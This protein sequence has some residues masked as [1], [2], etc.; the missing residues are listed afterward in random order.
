MKISPILLITYIR[1]SN[2]KRIIN[3]LKKQNISSIYIY[4]NCPNRSSKNYIL[5]KM[6]SDK[7]RNLSKKLNIKCNKN[8][9][10]QNNHKQ[11][12][13]S[14]K[15]SIDWF[16]KNEKEGIILEDDIIP[17]KSFL[18]FCTKLLSYYRYNKRVYHISGFNHLGKIKS[19][20]SYHFS[21]YTHVWGWASWRR[22]WK[23][24]DYEMKGFNNKLN[25][26]NSKQECAYRNYLYKK[27]KQR[28]I[29]TWDYQWDFSIRKN[30]GYCIRPNKNLVKNV[31]FNL[32]AS[33]T[34]IDLKNLS[35][36]KTYNISK[37]KHPKK[38]IFSDDIDFKIFKKFEYKNL[39]LKKIYDLF[40]SFF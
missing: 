39:A 4:N 25:L 40:K 37:I 11:V 15:Q 24:Y 7:I 30:Y 38:I 17:N 16:F 8:F 10:F 5:D 19:K 3:I 32:S 35:G 13:L 9:F 31:G 21:R 34:K 14:I 28:E 29:N 6:N 1:L 18:Y 27:T 2:F 22:A 20:N 33:N 12:G 23:K 26:F 36:V